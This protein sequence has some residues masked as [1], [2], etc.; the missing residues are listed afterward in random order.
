MAGSAKRLP[1]L[2]MPLRG[3]GW[4]GP[5]LLVM[6]RPGYC[7]GA[8]GAAAYSEGPAS[9]ACSALRLM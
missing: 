6:R 3:R 2:L 9:Y 5:I 4:T 1:I 7:T 8:A